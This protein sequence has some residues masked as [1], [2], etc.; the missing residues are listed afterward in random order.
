MLIKIILLGFIVFVVGR[1]IG[2]WRTGDVGGA[3]V[4][5]W[6]LFWAAV[7][8]VVI[9]PQVT[10]PVAQYMGVARGADLL[11]YVSVLVLFFLVFRL[12]ATTHRLDRQLTTLTREV[13]I[14]RAEEPSDS[15]PR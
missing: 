7:A 6:L 2:R 15:S 8:S 10:D 14:D 9:W 4:T 3:E 5:L 1:V 11:V 12:L 13:A